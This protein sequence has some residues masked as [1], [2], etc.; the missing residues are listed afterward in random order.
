MMDRFLHKTLAYVCDKYSGIGGQRTKDPMIGSW[1]EESSWEEKYKPDHSTKLQR[2]LWEESEPC[3]HWE[4]SKLCGGGIP[5]DGLRCIVHLARLFTSERALM[6]EI[7]GEECLAE[8]GNLSI[9]AEVGNVS[10]FA[11]GGNISIF[12]TPQ[13]CGLN[14]AVGYLE[15]GRRWGCRC[16]AWRARQLL[17]R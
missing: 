11:E 9:V 1:I 6:K 12:V 16:V 4:E 8:S 7:L 15:T 3:D 14:R 10:V 5:L 13:A 17:L 2:K